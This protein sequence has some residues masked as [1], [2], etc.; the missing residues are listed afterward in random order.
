M[1]SKRRRDGITRRQF[2]KSTGV[3]AGIIALGPA[4][5]AAAA[6]W[7]KGIKTEK[8][9]VVVVGAGFSALS[10]AVQAKL[11]GTD[12]LVLEKTKEDVTG[13][14]S[15][16]CGGMICVRLDDTKQARDNYYEDFVKKSMG[17]GDPD[18]TRLLAEN[19]QDGVDWLKIQGA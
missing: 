10:A 4:S 9:G 12:V 3:G 7:P 14:N 11:N 1:S 13:G 2:L 6:Q 16:I 8:H 15:R 18:L 17:N 5:V 19:T